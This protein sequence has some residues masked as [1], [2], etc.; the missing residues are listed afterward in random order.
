MDMV[1]ERSL[2]DTTTELLKYLNDEE[3][4]AIQ[5]VARAFIIKSSEEDYRPLTEE[6]LAARIDE[7]LSDVEAGRYE[8]S[9]VVIEKLRKEL[10]L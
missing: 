2:L 6:E 4:A 1:H 8:D 5:S 9:D 3:L 10:G 7:G